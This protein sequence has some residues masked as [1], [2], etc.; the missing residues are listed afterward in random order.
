MAADHLTTAALY[1]GSKRYGR[2]KAVKNK[3][4]STG[5]KNWRRHLIASLSLAVILTVTA[6][7]IFGLTYFGFVERTKLLNRFGA[8]SVFS[9]GA[10]YFLAAYCLNKID[11][12]KIPGRKNYE[13]EN[14]E[15]LTGQKRSKLILAAAL[16][17]SLSLSGLMASLLAEFSVISHPLFSGHFN[18]WLILNVGPIILLFNYRRDR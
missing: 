3:R 15:L 5:K 2:K 1:H 16:F 8:M 13:N 18:I 11:L 12:R 17:L 14:S 7:L 9:A 4:T 6:F 10:L